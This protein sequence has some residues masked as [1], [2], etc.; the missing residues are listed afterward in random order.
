MEFT[1]AILDDVIV[2]QT[3][4]TWEDRQQLLSR[5]VFSGPAMEVGTALMVDILLER[6]CLRGWSRE[7]PLSAETVYAIPLHHLLQLALRVG[8]YVAVG[9]VGGES[10]ADPL[11]SANGPPEMPTGSSPADT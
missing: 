9:A 7:E 11:L 5:G 3:D 8:Q 6:G 2:W 10:D 4:I 1:T